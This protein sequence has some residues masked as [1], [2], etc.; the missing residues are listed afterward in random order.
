ML[1]LK[2]CTHHPQLFLF[3][4]L[5]YVGGGIFEFRWCLWSS[6]KSIGS[7]D[8]GVMGSGNQT[9]VLPRISACFC[10]TT[11]PS[12]QSYVFFAFLFSFSKE[13]AILC[14]FLLGLGD[15]CFNTQ[16]LSILGFLYSEDSA[17]AFAVFKFVQVT[18]LCCSRFPSR[19]PRSLGV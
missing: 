2:A 1:G 3:K 4:L 12:S 15:S 16:L 17:P 6:K 13:V 10:L 5:I 14:S 11:E 7:S 19:C 8:A 9:Q 18:G